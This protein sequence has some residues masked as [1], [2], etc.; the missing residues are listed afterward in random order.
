MRGQT[1]LPLRRR[2]KQESACLCSTL[3][4]R[5]GKENRRARGVDTKGGGGR[6]NPLL[7]RR[8]RTFFANTDAFLFQQ[9]VKLYILICMRLIIWSLQRCLRTFCHVSENGVG[10]H[11]YI[12]MISQREEGMIIIAT[13]RVVSKG[14]TLTNS[15]KCFTHAFSLLSLRI[16]WGKFYEDYYSFLY[17]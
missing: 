15:V 2:S 7:F 6:G 3:W 4:A 13:T 12:R 5:K 9:H 17:R 8:A 10:M 1:I 16:P 14:W 11:E